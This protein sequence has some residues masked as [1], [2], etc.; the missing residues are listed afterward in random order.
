MNILYVENH[1]RFAVIA[2]E[3]YLSEHTVMVV[4]SL[5]AARQALERSR[6]DLILLDQDL[7]DGKGTELAAE[8]ASQPERPLILAA[9]S[10]AA[11]NEALL[12]AG[13]DGVCSKMEFQGIE[14]AIARLFSTR[15]VE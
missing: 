15:R 10:H 2:V 9:S 8:L 6:F 12:K 13:A 1:K 3:R 7:D 14:V 5:V 11:G 4:P